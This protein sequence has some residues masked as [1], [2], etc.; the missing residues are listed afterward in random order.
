M[1]TLWEQFNQSIGD[2]LLSTINNYIFLRGYLE[3]EQKHLVKGIAV[4]TETYKE[5]KK[6]LEAC[7]GEKNRIIQAHL[8]YLKDVKPIKYVTPEA[9][10]LTYIDCNR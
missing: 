3:E 4:V 6:I 5:T 9:L 1:G 8:D 10:N 7:Y 2:L